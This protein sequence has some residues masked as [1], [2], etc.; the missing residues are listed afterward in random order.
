[1]KRMS[2][3]AKIKV[4]PLGDRVVVRPAAEN[5]RGTKT[6]AGIFIP[7][8]VEKERSEQGVVVAVGPGKMNDNGKRVPMTVKEG[9]T[10]LFSKY[11]PDEIKVDGKEL[12][13][14]SES[15][16]LAVIG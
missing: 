1:L 6:K 10:V 15:S 13:I 2:T 5:E 11:G 9:Q 14:I 12:F 8:T 16:I 7:E 4:R 3:A